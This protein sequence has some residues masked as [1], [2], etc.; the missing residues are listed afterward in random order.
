MFQVK[1]LL[2]PAIVLAA[3]FAALHA[4][5]VY[6]FDEATIE[7][8]TEARAQGPALFSALGVAGSATLSGHLASL[9]YGFLLP[10]IG[11]LYAVRLTA[12]LIADKVETGEISYWMSLPH[13]RARYVWRQALV[14][15]ILTAIPPL[16]GL[17]GGVAG[18][19]VLKADTPLNLAGYGLLVLGLYLWMVL[20]GA[21]G[22]V[23]SAGSAS[24]ARAARV[25]TIV[26]L[27][28]FALGIAGMATGVP[29]W[30][31]W[32]SPRWLYAPQEL[33]RGVMPARTGALPALAVLLTLL[34]VWRFST[35]DL[36]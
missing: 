10:L 31:R 23:F 24:R 35:R 8:L 1:K 5:A 7:T 21:I 6:L 32:L 20:S 18:T 36:E 15:L 2:W 22:F 11:G 16:G 4:G 26:F 33:A 3:L 13:S 30:V 14:L 29:N 17:L 28:L 12:N 9:L 25:G 27:L 34:A 19:L